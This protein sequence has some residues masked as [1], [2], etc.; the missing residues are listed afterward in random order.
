[1]QIKP[2]KG[3][4]KPSSAFSS[5][6]L[7]IYSHFLS[8]ILNIYIVICLRLLI[9]FLLDS[10]Y[11][12]KGHI[13]VPSNISFSIFA[14]LHILFL[15]LHILLFAFIIGLIAKKIIYLKIFCNSTMYFKNKQFK[16]MLLTFQKLHL[17][18]VSIHRNVTSSP[19]RHHIII[20]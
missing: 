6:H 2:K 13:S 4:T 8:F 20:I 7:M 18:N 3:E 11:R 10:P 19:R 15:V 12:S 16:S 9:V 1:M 17:V 5:A 14:F